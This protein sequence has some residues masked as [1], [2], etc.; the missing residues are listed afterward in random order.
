MTGVIY[1]A[2]TFVGLLP[3][4]EPEQYDFQVRAEDNGNPKK[5]QSTRVNVSVR[6]IGD[7]SIHEPV[8]TTPNQ[9]VEVTES[10]IPG[11]LIT[12]IQATDEDNDQLWYDIVGK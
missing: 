5:S 9:H 8:I 11:Y 7:D 10:D 6:P 2:K 4:G 12:L 1:A 3:D